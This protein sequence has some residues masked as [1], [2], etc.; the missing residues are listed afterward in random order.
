MPQAK[1]MHLLPLA[2]LALP[3][4]LLA[5]SFAEL[6]RLTDL[7]ATEQGGI[8]AARQQ[9][10]R[11]EY[12]EALATLE[13][14]MAAYPRSPAAQL[15]HAVYLCRIDDRQGGMVEIERMNEDEFGRQNIN[16]ARDQ[17]S[18][19]YQEPA[20]NL[21]PPAPVPVPPPAVSSPGTD[22]SPASQPAPPPPP[23]GGKD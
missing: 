14:V 11:G 23:Q 18:R 5:Q 9:A 21:A 19:P 8:D 2:L 3:V 4:P 10:G 15:L 16:D 20:R 22:S 6:D 17:C 13:R 12:L 1:L 7:T